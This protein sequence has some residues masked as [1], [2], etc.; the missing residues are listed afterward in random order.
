[1]WWSPDPRAVIF[2][3]SLH[4][5]RSLQKTLRKAPFTI[6]MDQ[7]FANVLNACAGPRRHGKH[8][9]S[10]TWLNADMKAA[11]LKL[12]QQGYAHS[13]EVY[14][15]DLLVGGIYGVALGRVFFGESMFSLKANA[16]K[17]AMV[18]LVDKLISWNFTLIDCQVASSHLMRLGASLMP[19]PQFL[20]HLTANTKLESEVSN[21]QNN[22][23]TG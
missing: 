12:H 14:E 9:E 1:M 11:Y 10:G 17:V 3:D 23:P 5:S 6:K 8:H 7:Q 19:R 18:H 21:W 4:V 13:I 22:R 20:K 15:N 2:L 16:S